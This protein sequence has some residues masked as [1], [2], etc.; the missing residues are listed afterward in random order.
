MDNLL[1]VSH[2]VLRWAVIL[3]GLYAITK[4]VR[5]VLFKQEYTSNHNLSATLFVAS[6]H[7]QIVLG[8]FLYVARGW[9]AKLGHMGD[10]M[11]N[12]TSR[13]WTVE[14]AFTMLLAAVLIQI[15]RSKSKKATEIAKKHKLA[16]IFFTIGFI[17]I[18][19]MIPW[20]FRGEV[21]KPLWP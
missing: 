6:V 21:A 19:L 2:N 17:L 7:L 20:P 18:L 10:V 4:A 8:L 1:L 15:G 13:F 14:H 11:G 16:A 9:A 3:F 5:G 12:A